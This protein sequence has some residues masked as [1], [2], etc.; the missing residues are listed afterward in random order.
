MQELMGH[1]DPFTPHARG[2][3]P[4]R[5]GG[6]MYAGVYPACA[7]ID[8]LSRLSTSSCWCLPRMRGDRPVAKLEGSDGSSFTPHAR[9]STKTGAYIELAGTV[10]P[11]CAGIDLIIFP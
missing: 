6:V 2:S 7:G 11:A 5:F 9:G 3:T 1:A 8:R 10:Y 4:H